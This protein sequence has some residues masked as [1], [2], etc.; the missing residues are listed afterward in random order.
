MHPLMQI[1]SLVNFESLVVVTVH[2]DGDN[3]SQN[4]DTNRWAFQR[5]EPG[6]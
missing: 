2:E 6:V 1:L 5:W 3:H 4:T